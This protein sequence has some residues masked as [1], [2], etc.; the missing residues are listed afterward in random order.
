MEKHPRT[1]LVIITEAAIEKR[2]VADS[3]RLGAQGH[4]VHDVRG[5]T[6]LSTREALWEKDGSGDD[7]IIPD[8]DASLPALGRL[9]KDS[10]GLLILSQDGV[11]AKAII[12]PDSVLTK[13]YE[14][15]VEG[16][17][18]ERKLNLLRRGLALD[19]RQLRQAKVT[20]TG[21]QQLRFVLSEGRNRQ[22]R[23][24]CELVELYVVDLLRTRIGTLD[25]G[26]LPEGQ[27]RHMTPDER[28]ELVEGY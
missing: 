11:L 20:R 28:N 26:N 17:I 21:E 19:G 16:E 3:Q 27:W 18:T 6:R 12:G 25:L 2:L 13:Q 1:L 7:P 9:D 5:G 8:V 22:I 23:R 15:T 4:T 24:M 10:R 14:V